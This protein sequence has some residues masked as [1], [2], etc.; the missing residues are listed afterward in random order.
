MC[1]GVCVGV[2]VCLKA[3]EGYRLKL[4]VSLFH[5]I[6]EIVSVSADFVGL[7]GSRLQDPSVSASPALE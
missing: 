2:C 3:C 6:F 7:V 5:L 1:V 4:V